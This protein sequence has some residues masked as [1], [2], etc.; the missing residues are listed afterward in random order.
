MRFHVPGMS[1]GHCTDAIKKEIAGL[2]ATA[3]MT[4]DLEQKTVTVTT[5]RSSNEVVA[6]IKAAGYDAA[7]L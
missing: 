3:D 1:C 5:A 7:P 4:T 2:D 6:A